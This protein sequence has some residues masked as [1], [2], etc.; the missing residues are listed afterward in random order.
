MHGPTEMLLV[1][2]TLFNL[3]AFAKLTPFALPICSVVLERP[4]WTHEKVLSAM[5][6]LSLTDVLN[7]A[8]TTLLRNVSV[9]CLAHG[10]VDNATVSWG[11]GFEA[12]F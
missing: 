8:N 11:A 9:S 4:Y 6:N 3:P 12:G 10:N 7:F 2:N 1:T 5:Q